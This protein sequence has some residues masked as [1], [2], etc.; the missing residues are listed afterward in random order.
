MIFFY[1]G[2]TLGTFK[3]RETEKKRKSQERDIIPPTR[4]EST[5]KPAFGGSGRHPNHLSDKQEATST[6]SP[7]QM[8]VLLILCFRVRQDIHQQKLISVPLIWDQIFSI[9][10]HN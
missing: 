1:D 8:T 4:P 7:S 2:L 3:Q 10:I 6:L 9:T 5:S